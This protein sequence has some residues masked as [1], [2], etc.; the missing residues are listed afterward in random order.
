M[1][2]DDCRVA[3]RLPG[4]K[5]VKVIYRRGPD[6]IPP[7]KIEHHHV[8][9]RRENPNGR[10]R[11]NL[12]NNRGNMRSFIPIV[13]M[14]YLWAVNVPSPVFAQQSF[15]GR[16]ETCGPIVGQTKQD[17]QNV[18]QFCRVVPEGAAVG[19]YAIESLLWVKVTRNIAEAMRADRLGA[20][21][22]VKNWMTRWKGLSGSEVVTIQVEWRDVLIAEGQTTVFSGDRVT[23]P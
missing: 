14:V 16:S 15:S 5:H 21:Q 6:E 12:Q 10:S 19:A 7:R 11:N 4:C 1:A 18:Q 22:L 2:I 20:E 17:I 13:L 8:I 9:I 23:I 3:K